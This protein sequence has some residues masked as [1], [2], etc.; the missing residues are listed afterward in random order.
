MPVFVLEDSNYAG[1]IEDDTV[2]PAEV[3]KVALQIKPFKDDD[4]NEIKK[5]VFQFRVDDP[6]SPHDGTML[7][8]ETYPSFTTH[9]RNRLRQWSEILLDTQL[10]PGY[11]LDT[12]S[13]IGTRCRLIVGLRKNLKGEEK[14][15]VKDLIPLNGL[16]SYS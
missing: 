12:D 3:L 4:G 15:W 10:P 2:V 5:V 14:N 16:A 9:P 6:D 7:W 1:P 13:L 11:T 8:G